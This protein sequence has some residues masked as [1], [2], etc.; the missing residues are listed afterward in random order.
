MKNNYCTRLFLFIFITLG[1]IFVSETTLAQYIN[2]Q[3]GSDG[4]SS[5][6]S[7]AC[8]PGYRLA[9]SPGY[10]DRGYYHRGEYYCARYERNYYYYN[11]G[12]SF[13]YR[14]GH[15]HRHHYYR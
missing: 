1:S 10:W 4:Y 14:S 5:R 9:Y 6:G 13:Y 7:Y 12:P 11:E 2:V 15:H 8:P 3:F